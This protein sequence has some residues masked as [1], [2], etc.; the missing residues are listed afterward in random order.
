MQ[1][2]LYLITARSL[3]E[4]SKRKQREVGI[5]FLYC[6]LMVMSADLQNGMIAFKISYHLVNEKGDQ[7]IYS[8][9][10]S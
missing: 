8:N 10:Q 7:R 4:I 9:I 5:L 1:V 3:H 2:G 6:A